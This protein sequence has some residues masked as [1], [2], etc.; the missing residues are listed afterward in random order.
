[1]WIHPKPPFSHR[2]QKDWRSCRTS[3]SVNP[4]SLCGAGAAHWSWKTPSISRGSFS[5]E[6][7][8]EIG[9]TVN[10]QSRSVETSDSQRSNSVL[11]SRERVCVCVDLHWCILPACRP[12]YRQEETVLAV[13]G[14]GS[15]KLGGWRGRVVQSAALAPPGHQVFSLPTIRRL[16]SLIQNDSWFIKEEMKPQH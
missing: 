16:I 7:E 1:M 9:E 4:A 3:V 5:K 14:F 10:R 8:R 13:S 15:D 12:N 11:W 2:S 6:W